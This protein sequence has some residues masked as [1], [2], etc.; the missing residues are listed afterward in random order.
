MEITPPTWRKTM[1]VKAQYRIS[2]WRWDVP[3]ET[4]STPTFEGETVE[5]CDHQAREHFQAVSARQETAWE[6]MDIVRI[7]TPAVAEKTTFIER[8][9]RQQ[10][11]D[12]YSL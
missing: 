11:N 12:E 9:N 6:G 4:Y 7:D 1:P 10:N 3:K 5:E 2:T 8:N